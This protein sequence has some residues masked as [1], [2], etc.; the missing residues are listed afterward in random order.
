MDTVV[1]AATPWGQAAV[2]LLRLSGPEALDVARAVCPGGPAWRPR[3]VCLRRARAGGIVAD[4]VLAVWMPGPRSYTGEDIVELSCHGNPVLVELLLDA[5]VA[6]GARPARPGEFTR[7]A[8]VNGRM[9]LLQAEA[10]SALIGARSIEGLALARAGLEGAVGREVGALYERL[11]DLASELEARFDSAGE[12]L[13]TVDDAELARRLYAVAAEARGAAD[14]WRAGRARLHG[15]RVALIGPVNAGKSSLFNHLLGETRALV[16][17]TPGTTR[18]VVERARLVDGLELS[19]LDTAGERPDAEPLEREGQALAR[20]L[21]ADVDLFLIVLPLH[22]PPGPDLAAL[23]ARAAGTPAL[24]VGTHADLVSGWNP[25]WVDHRV[26]SLTGEGID[27]LRAA[28]RAAVG[29]AGPSG[30]ATLVLSQ[31]QHDLLRSVAGH[32]SEAANALLGPAGPV[33][34]AE[35]VTAALERLGELRGADAR[36]DVLDRV[37]QRFCIGK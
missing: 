35:E 17:P 21:T 3:R 10:V 28:V 20:A 27:G 9:D 33:V 36:E 23:R 4:H 14:T 15:A 22:R 8:L 26:S 2:A 16:S 18:D 5:C 13:E 12:D 24:V 32:A 29:E 11:L 25:P 34:A 30:A 31:R 37:F 6:A 1:A 7:R 19:F